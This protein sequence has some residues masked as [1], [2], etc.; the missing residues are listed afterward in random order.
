MAAINLLFAILVVTVS[1]VFAGGF[2]L[3]E[4]NGLEPLTSCMP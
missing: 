1:P 3:V 4:D 2:V